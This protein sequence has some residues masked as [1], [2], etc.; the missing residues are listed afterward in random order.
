M[1]VSELAVEL[2]QAAEEAGFESAWTVE[3][4][5]VPEGHASAY[6]YSPDGRMAGGVL[7]FPLPD[8]LIWMAYVAARTHTIKLGTVVIPTRSRLPLAARKMSTSCRISRN[9]ESTESSCPSTA[10]RLWL[11]RPGRPRKCLPG[12]GG[13][14]PSRAV[15][16]A[17]ATRWE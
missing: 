14:K 10:R 11:P 15:R 7:D 9:L 5:V 4:T 17:R 2:V 3:H 8:P 1:K 13:S 12:R 6:P 16:W